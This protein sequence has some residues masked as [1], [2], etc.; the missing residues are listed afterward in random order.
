MNQLWAILKQPKYI[1]LIIVCQQYKL[2][3]V[4]K[5]N[6]LAQSL[7][8]KALYKI[9][10]TKHKFNPNYYPSVARVDSSL[11]ESTYIFPETIKQNA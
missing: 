7:Q 1:V 5:H 3:S 10:F 8:I 6:L 9:M 4:T 2:E 11:I